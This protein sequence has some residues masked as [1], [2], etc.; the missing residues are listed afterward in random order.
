MSAITEI[1]Q[2]Q[3]QQEALEYQKDQDKMNT[4][5]KLL[6][7][8]ADKENFYL[9]LEADKEN[10]K[11]DFHLNALNAINNAGGLEYVDVTYD[12]QKD[13]TSLITSVTPLPPDETPDLTSTQRQARYVKMLDDTELRHLVVEGDISASL[14]N[15]DEHNQTISRV[16]AKYRPSDSFLS[17]EAQVYI[18]GSDA[19]P[20]FLTAHDIDVTRE[21]LFEVDEE[22]I[23]AWKGT[24]VG[25]AVA[26]QLGLLADD[27][28]VAQI[29]DENMERRWVAAKGAWEG[30]EDYKTQT[31]YAKIEQETMAANSRAAQNILDDPFYIQTADRLQSNLTA[32]DSWVTVDTSG[33]LVAYDASKNTTVKLNELK[34]R[35]D[36]DDMID[37]LM[38][39]TASAYINY[40]AELP[41]T[42]G[43][44]IIK[45]INADNP[46]WGAIVQMSVKA[47][48]EIDSKNMLYNNYKKV[49][50]N[51]PGVSTEEVAVK[52]KSFIDR[53]KN[54]VGDEKVWDQGVIKLMDE[55]SMLENID[56]DNISLTEKKQL[57]VLKKEL[58]KFYGYIYQEDYQVE[59]RN[60][61]NL[62]QGMKS[63]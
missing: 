47:K 23:P 1:I 17:Q 41:V 30:Q 7:L 2:M 10:S 24:D 36:T 62:Y 57:G 27:E 53:I 32:M 20:D 16:I 56:E 43:S 14:K 42:V 51:Q 19:T 12:K 58:D 8:E 4:A 18:S 61:L 9:T 55:I 34:V 40:L 33:Y 13:G 37:M 25:L 45:N 11:K 46:N 22:M 3:M 59:F 6:A 44:E 26:H 21:F 54:W 31:E 5:F 28:D 50:M 35:K 39:G 63:F 15:F 48:R 29:S 52:N 49:A 60:W 38:D